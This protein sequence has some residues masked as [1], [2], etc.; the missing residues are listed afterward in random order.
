MIFRVRQQDSR[1]TTVA[2][3]VRLYQYSAFEKLGAG[4]RRE[5]I[6]RPLGCRR[7]L[8]VCSDAH[9]RKH[10]ACVCACV[11]FVGFLHICQNDADP[12]RGDEHKYDGIQHLEWRGKTRHSSAR[13]AAMTETLVQV[14]VPDEQHEVEFVG[15]QCARLM[16]QTGA[17]VKPVDFK[18]V[19]YIVLVV[20]ALIDFLYRACGRCRT[21]APGDP[22]PHCPFRVN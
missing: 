10:L 19:K 2:Y 22:T 12:K 11:L 5:E 6:L 18:V 1:W 7:A 15:L 3:T 17:R 4:E 14:F 13:A 8:V 20:L 9:H 21:S 16:D